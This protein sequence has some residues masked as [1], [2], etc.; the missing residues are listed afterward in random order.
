[1]RNA[2]IG[3]ATRRPALKTRLVRRVVRLVIPEH[4]AAQYFR[5]GKAQYS[6]GWGHLHTVCPRLV[7]HMV[8]SGGLELGFKFAHRAQFDCVSFDQMAAKHMKNRLGHGIGA[9]N[10][11]VEVVPEAFRD[12]GAQERRVGSRGR[13]YCHIPFP[14]PNL[15]GW[16]LTTPG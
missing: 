1:M 11:H 3:G 12:V 5:G 7:Y 8:Q 9:E 15:L 4:S 6:A 13:N 16:K 2:S 10:R 14:V